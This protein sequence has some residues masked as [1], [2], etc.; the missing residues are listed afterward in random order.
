MDLGP[1]SALAA[2][3][4]ALITHAQMERLGLTARQ[5]RTLRDRR[6]IDLVHRGVYRFAGV[7]PT[8]D[9]HVHAAV[10]ATSP[11]SFIGLR[12]ALAWWGLPRRDTHLVE[13]VTSDERRVRVAG[14][15]S[16]RTVDL[17][18]ADRRR[19]RG[20]PVTSVERALFDAGRFLSPKQVGAAL[21]HAVRD[22][23]TTYDRFQRRVE[24]LGRSGRNGTTTAREVLGARGYG[25]GFGFEKA[26]RGLLRDAGFPAPRREYRVRL[27]AERYRVDF[28]YPD[29]MVGIEC[30]SSEWHELAYQR[31]YDLRRQNRIQ[32]ADLHLLRFT[33]SRLRYQQDEVVGEIRDALTSRAG[34][35]PGPAEIFP[36]GR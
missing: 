19:H 7:E 34:R 17:P 3:Q 5:I 8:W 10:L 36:D 21:D 16:Y 13:V 31:E 11:D 20:L 25:D 30:D 6:V 29:S 26:M 24:E 4:H 2:T 12:S 32:N 18:A 22:G 33:V 9:Q 28:A 35:G 14:V 27:D 15:R 23:L 1:V